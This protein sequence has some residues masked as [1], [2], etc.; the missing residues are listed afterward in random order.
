[1]I[2]SI[3]YVLVIIINNINSKSHSQTT[4]LF[5]QNNLYD[6]FIYFK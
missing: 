6:F 2:L 3:L 1:M 5:Q 4:N